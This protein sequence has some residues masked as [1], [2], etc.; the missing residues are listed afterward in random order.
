MKPTKSEIEKAESHLLRHA[1]HPLQEKVF[2]AIER[3]EGG[4]QSI[5]NAVLDIFDTALADQKAEFE[6]KLD[7]IRKALVKEYDEICSCKLL[8]EEAKENLNM[9]KVQVICSPCLGKNLTLDTFDIARNE[10]GV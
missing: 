10:D 1:D 5:T 4:R 6:K 8:R 7:G 2:E 9:N 3:T